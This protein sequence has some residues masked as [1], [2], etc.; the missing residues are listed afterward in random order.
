M[1][2]LL[3]RDPLRISS[4]ENWHEVIQ[5][6]YLDTLLFI[7]SFCHKISLISISPFH[8]EEA[9]CCMANPTGKYLIPQHCINDWTFPT[10]CSRGIENKSTLSRALN[11][12][13]CGTECTP[14]GVH[15]LHRAQAVLGTELQPEESGECSFRGTGHQLHILQELEVLSS[16]LL[17]TNPLSLTLKYLRFNYY[18]TAWSYVDCNSFLSCFQKKFSA[19]CTTVHKFIQ[20]AR[21]GVEFSF[22]CSELSPFAKATFI[23]YHSSYSTFN[24]LKYQRWDITNFFIPEPLIVFL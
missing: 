4:C 1:K 21:R 19:H 10:A 15:Q 24:F 20:N 22:S 17:C 14:I 23:T 9:V 7:W 6:M 5:E 13:L 12:P 3:K 18:T 11:T 16:V 8:T 2:L